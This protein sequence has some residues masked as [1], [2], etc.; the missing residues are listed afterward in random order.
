MAAPRGKGSRSADHLFK[1]FLLQYAAKD[2]NGIVSALN[3]INVQSDLYRFRNLQSQFRGSSGGGQ[4]NHGAD[5][6]PELD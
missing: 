4:A 5:G 2:F 1:G 6:N 3:K